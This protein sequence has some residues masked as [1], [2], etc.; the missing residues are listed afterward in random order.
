MDCRQRILRVAA[1]DK[2]T[3]VTA[4]WIKTKKVINTHMHQQVQDIES[5]FRFVGVNVLPLTTA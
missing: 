2:E 5:K 4:K 3:T 1:V